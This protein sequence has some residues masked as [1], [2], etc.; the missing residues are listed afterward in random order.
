MLLVTRKIIALLPIYSL[1]LLCSVLF[2]HSFSQDQHSVASILE[3]SFCSCTIQS[4]FWTVKQKAGSVPAPWFCFSCC[5]GSRLH[6]AWCHKS[7]P[8]QGTGLKAGG[9]HQL[10]TSLKAVPSPVSAKGQ[11]VSFP[12]MAGRVTGS[13]STSYPRR[14]CSLALAIEQTIISPYQPANPA[15]NRLTWLRQ[16]PFLG[17]GN[18][19]VSILKNR[20]SQAD[21][22]P[23]G[24]S[25]D[26]TGMA[27]SGHK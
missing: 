23:R 19:V 13:F 12:H 24:G 17:L 15:L 18:E 14:D 25:L 1:S 6:P 5:C 21:A 9:S 10:C 26:S 16:R 7:P 8:L 2:F 20:P 11:G 22:D 3:I 27:E 4:L